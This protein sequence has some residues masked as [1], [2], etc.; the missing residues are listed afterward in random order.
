MNRD[1][2]DREHTQ[3]VPKRPR[4]TAPPPVQQRQSYGGGESSHHSQQSHDADDDIQEV[5]PV[6]SEPRDQV[7]IAQEQVVDNSYQ[8]TE[9][10]VS[11]VGQQQQQH[12]NE[13]TLALDTAEQYDESYDYGQYG[14]GSYDDGAGVIDPN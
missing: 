4:P 14:D 5:V 1:P 11:R 13:G 10:V 7:V 9:Q 2:P 12:S 3:P 6:K 8:E